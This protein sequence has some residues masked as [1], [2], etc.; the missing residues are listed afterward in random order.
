MLVQIKMTK[1]KDIVLCGA[2]RSPFQLRLYCI[3]INSITRYVDSSY[4]MPRA[5][6]CS[7]MDY[8]ADFFPR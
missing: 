1:L 8:G 6:T 5:G 7:H 4:D 3:C 2:C